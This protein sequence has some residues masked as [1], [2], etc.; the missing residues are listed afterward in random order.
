MA[1]KCALITGSSSGIGKAIALKLANDGYDIGINYAHN[2]NAAQSV[3]TE[4]RNIG[5]AADIFQVDIGNIPELKDLF[6]AFLNVFGK[7]DLLVNNAG[8]TRCRPFIDVNEELFDELCNTNFKSHYFLTQFAARNMIENKIH[9]NII[10]I[11]SIHQQT[12]MPETSVY[13][14]FKSA[15]AKFT[16]HA[17]VEL[18]PYGIRV[19]AVAPGAINTS[20]DVNER[21]QYLASRVPM[22][23]LGLPDEIASVVSFLVSDAASYINGANILVDGGILLPSYVDN[24]YTPRVV[25]D[26]MS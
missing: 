22:G 13:G 25:T 18:A 8:I 20:N 17:A 23:R 15:F 16:H 12:A 3:V 2:K 4:V 24:L 14:S 6:H 10:N 26:K 1:A 11:T 19:N 7:I 9:G 21:A 5:V